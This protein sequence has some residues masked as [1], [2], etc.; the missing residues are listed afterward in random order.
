MNM[1][2]ILA[3]AAAFFS[4]ALA[5]LVVWRER[6]SHG[7]RSFAAGMA[8]LAME[9][10]FNGLSLDTTSVEEMIYWQGWSLLSTSFLPGIWLF[11]SLCYGRGNYREFLS[12]WRYFLV[13]ALL[14]P[15]GLAV[16]FQGKLIISAGQTKAGQWI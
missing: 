10:I 15:T 1:V 7:H 4:G 13:L 11:F 12:R 14:I 9:S 8:V 5:F 16:L 2:A 3:F 6:G